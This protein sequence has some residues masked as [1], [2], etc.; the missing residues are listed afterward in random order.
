MSVKPHT[1]W[2]EYRCHKKLQVALSNRLATPLL[3][4][5]LP[6]PHY[7]TTA[8]RHCST[9]CASRSITA[10]HVPSSRVSLC[11]VCPRHCLKHNP[12]ISQLQP[13]LDAPSCAGSRASFLSR[14]WGYVTRPRVAPPHPIK[15]GP[16]IL[17]SHVLYYLYHHF[18]HYGLSCYH[19]HT[20]YHSLSLTHHTSSPHVLSLTAH[21]PSHGFLYRTFR[22]L[23]R[24]RLLVLGT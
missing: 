6:T 15:P 5:Q 7:H 11:T 14:P 17:S 12:L 23:P 10:W 4:G 21:F 13:H 3:A 2:I 1:H 9:S 18:D 8:L 22:L 19:T 20:T 24:N 16:A